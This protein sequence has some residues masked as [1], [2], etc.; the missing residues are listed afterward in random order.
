MRR[1]FIAFGLIVFATYCWASIVYQNQVDVPGY[2]RV[3]VDVRGGKDAATWAADQQAAF[4]RLMELGNKRYQVPEGVEA[5]FPAGHVMTVNDFSQYLETVPD[6]EPAR[7]ELLDPAAIY[8]LLAQN[9]TLRDSIP[10]PDNPLGDPLYFGGRP[11]DK[12]LLDDLRVRDIR[13]I[14]VSGH[15]APVNFQV[16]TAI[17]IALIFL[18]LVAALRP[19]LWDPFIVMLEKRR[20]ELEIGAEADRQNQQEATRYEEEKRRRYDDFARTAQALRLESRKKV[21]R[22]A[23]AIVKEAKDKEKAEKLVG[24]RELCAAA[25]VTRQR[26]DE[27]VDALAREV[28]DAL[29]PRRSGD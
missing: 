16:G 20:R 18:T 24:L 12:A 8:R 27:D 9:Y 14:T 26:L 28:A 17:M 7:L 29:T 11:L 15:A 3:V 6:G 2:A 10:H 5:P 23:G 25:E 19:I 4:Q 21:A 13:T 1:A 22:E